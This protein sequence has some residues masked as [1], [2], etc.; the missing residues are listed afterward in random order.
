MHEGINPDKPADFTRTWFAWSN[1]L[2]AELVLK[3]YREH[4]QLLAPS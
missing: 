3:T 2:F 1:S 4:P